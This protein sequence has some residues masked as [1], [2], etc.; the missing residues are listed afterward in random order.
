MATKVED[1]LH[2]KK[3]AIVSRGSSKILYSLPQDDILFAEFRP[4]VAINGKK[5]FRIKERPRIASELQ[6]FIFAYLETYQIPT[7][8][9]SQSGG[10]FLVKR[11]NI[12]PVAVTVR[13]LAS[14]SFAKR[15]KHF[16]SRQQLDFPIFEYV[17]KDESGDFLVNDT[18][19][20]ALQILSPDDF[21][22][23]NRLA[24]KVDAV[25][26]SFFER[27]G[28]ILVDITMKFGKHKGMIILGDEISPENITV[29][30]N[31]TGE[32]ISVANARDSREASKQYQLVYDRVLP[33]VKRKA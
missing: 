11:L 19:L 4:E 24:S 33:S 29:I 9:F 8:F 16:K 21:R 15:F 23:M 31:A 18:H 14:Q 3:G 20:Y 32:E 28:F 27:R 26:K 17:L 25:M 13:N 2:G 5:V 6:A 30:D 1:P 7:H 12:I 10:E 22:T